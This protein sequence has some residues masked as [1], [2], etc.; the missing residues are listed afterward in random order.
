MATIYRFLVESSVRGGASGGRKSGENSKKSTGKTTTL[1][2]ALSNNK[3]GV[4]HNRKTR[5][6][7]PLINKISAGTWEKANRVGRA[8]MGLVKFKT[9]ESGALKFAG[10]SKP[11]IAIII[12][13][14]IMSLLKYQNVQIRNNDVLNKYN[15]KSMESGN[16]A[17]RGEYSTSVNI[18][19]GKISYNQN[20]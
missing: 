13:L 15:F 12:Q 18:L 7:N 14:I 16:S 6:I 9:T 10:I 8:T 4:E 1:L 17:V 20:K 11:A 5:A 3:G 19:N 2:R